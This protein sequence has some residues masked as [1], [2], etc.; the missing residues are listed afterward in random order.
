M[1]NIISWFLSIWLYVFAAIGLALVISLKIKWKEWDWRNKIS[2]LA[3]IV[4]VL[5]VWEEWRIPG[6]FHYLYNLNAGSTALDRYPMSELTD[7]LTNSG[8]LL[9]GVVV[10]VIWGI[11]NSAAI[12]IFLTSILE[13]ILHTVSAFQSF[14]KFK[15]VGQSIVYSPG[16][17]TAILGFLPVAI[18]FI[19]YFIHKNRPTKWEWMIGTIAFV[20]TLLLFIKLP[21]ALLKDVNSIYPYHDKGFYEFVK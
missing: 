17:V 9:V 5:H 4:L 16:F 19:V 7:M 8:G 20:V 11:K 3:F 14:E 6:G 12:A 13:V 21:E 10:L 2:T 15:D 1:S 18:A